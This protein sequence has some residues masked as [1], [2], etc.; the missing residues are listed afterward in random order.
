[1]FRAKGF[2]WNIE[3]LTIFEKI[4]S[5]KRVISIII[6]FIINPA[7]NCYLIKFIFTFTIIIANKIIQKCKFED[8][9][10]TKEMLRSAIENRA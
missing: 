6:N 10:R 2:D 7:I 1:M 3:Q 4:E 8:N 5:L 9:D